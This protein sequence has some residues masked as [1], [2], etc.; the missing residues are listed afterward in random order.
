MW[1]IY[2]D[3]DSFEKMAKAKV[4]HDA[5]LLAKVLYGKGKTNTTQ[6]QTTESKPATKIQEGPKTRR[7]VKF[8]A[9]SGKFFV[10]PSLMHDDCHQPC[11]E[12]R[13]D[14]LHQHCDKIDPP[15][16]LPTDHLHDNPCEDDPAC[17]VW[18]SQDYS[19]LPVRLPDQ[20]SETPRLMP[21]AKTDVLVFARKSSSEYDKE[22]EELKDSVLAW[23][24][25]YQERQNKEQS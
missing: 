23:K 25:R 6:A 18:R 20:F 24:L 5:R 2:D 11:D 22:R 9:Q 7:E 14:V 16:S 4:M 1:D 8:S 15:S 10:H 19:F 17:Y 12:T 21:P 13:N 3:D